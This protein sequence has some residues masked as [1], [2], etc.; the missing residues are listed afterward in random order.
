MLFYWLQS[1]KLLKNLLTRDDNY[2]FLY[3][4]L[5]S[6]LCLFF[7]VYFLGTDITNEVFQRIRKIVL[8]LFIIFEL[9]AQIFLTRK[10]YLLKNDLKDHIS[11]LVLNIKIIYSYIIVLITL[12]IIIIL[13]TSGF[14][15]NMDYI[16]EWNYFVT[17]LLFYLLSSIIWKK[18]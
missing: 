4:G 8:M 14:T 2:W 12:L 10:L 1:N 13:G 6:S 7:H 15:S 11:K 16:M 5:F 9:F 17:L 18:N 3:L